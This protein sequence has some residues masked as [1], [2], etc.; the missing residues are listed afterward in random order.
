MVVLAEV[1]T[2]L[3]PAVDRGRAKHEKHDDDPTEDQ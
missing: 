2:G 3:G 1:R